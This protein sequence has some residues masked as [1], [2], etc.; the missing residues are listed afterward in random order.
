MDL[1]VQKRIRRNCLFFSFTAKFSKEVVC[2]HCVSSMMGEGQKHEKLNCREIK[3]SS[4]LF[5]VFSD[6]SSG[7]YILLVIPL[8]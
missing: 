8:H 1:V 6:F 4:E 3:L 5:Q 7:F 2:R